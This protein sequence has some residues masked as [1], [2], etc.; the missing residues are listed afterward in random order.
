SPIYDPDKEIRILG[1]AFFSRECAETMVRECEPD[2]FGDELN[3]ELFLAFERIIGGQSD[4]PMDPIGIG[5]LVSPAA[6]LRA[7]EIRDLWG[8][9]TSVADTTRWAAGYLRQA[10]EKRWLRDIGLEFLQAGTSRDTLAEDDLAALRQKVLDHQMRG[11]RSRTVSL[12]EVLTKVH[13]ELCNWQ[14]D[15]P[16]RVSSG[17]RDLDQR[18]GATPN[19]WLILI[20]AR[21][22]MGKTV[23]ATNIAYNIAAAGAPVLIVTLE[24]SVY[25]IG[26]TVLAPIANVPGKVLQQ[27][28]QAEIERHLQAITKGISDVWGVPITML[29]AP[30]SLA[31]IRRAAQDMMAAQGR[32]LGAVIVDRVEYVQDLQRSKASEYRLMLGNVTAGFKQLANE[33]ECP[34]FL[35]AELN[36]ECEKREDKRPRLSDIRESGA[37]EENAQRVIALYRDDYYDP[38]SRDKGITELIVLKNKGP[39]GT[40]PVAFVDS[41]PRFAD[42]DPESAAAWRARHWSNGSR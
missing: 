17:F 22:S 23:L 2:D 33:L 6:A 20:A 26:K 3:R 24:M 16:R 32:Q 12:N 31:D 11:K 29:G 27:G 10:S 39:I 7:W 18:V 21:P 8:E 36:R 30:A 42:L 19:T 40:V 1:T 5:S 14:D 35:V 25:E 37:L 9:A 34:V 38:T 15:D 4:A 41:Y 28:P 13:E